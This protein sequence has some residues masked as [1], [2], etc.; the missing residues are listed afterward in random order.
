[1]HADVKEELFEKPNH[2]A[3]QAAYRPVP[4]T[5]IKPLFQVS[6]INS[7]KTP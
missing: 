1:M 7:S 3:Q 2:F 5:S 6:H 4:W